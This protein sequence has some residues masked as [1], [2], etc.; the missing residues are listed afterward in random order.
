MALLGLF[1]VVFLPAAQAQPD[2]EDGP[3]LHSITLSSRNVTAGSNLVVSLDV[4][5]ATGIAQVFVEIR[6]PGDKLRLHSGTD[7][8]HGQGRNQ[9][10]LQCPFQL[11]ATLPA[12]TYDVWSLQLNDV[13]W[14]TAH[15]ASPADFQEGPL[16]RLTFTVASDNNDLEG[17]I[18]HGFEVLT[19]TAPAGGNA[20]FRLT[21]SDSTG[22]RTLGVGAQHSDGSPWTSGP[23]AVSGTSGAY[24]C[25]IPV[26]KAF[27]TGT[28]HVLSIDLVDV[29][30]VATSH[31][32]T[33]S[34]PFP[35][36]GNPTFAVASPS[37]DTTAPS[38][39]RFQAPLGPVVRGQQYEVR[40]WVD[41]A[42]DLAMA[43]PVFQNDVGK[44]YWRRHLDVQPADCTQWVSR[45]IPVVCTDVVPEWFP[46]GRVDLQVLFLKDLATNER[47]YTGL[48]GMGG[49]RIP[50]DGLNRTHFWIAPRPLGGRGPPLS[51]EPE[52]T[53]AAAGT[54]LPV[55]GLID[56]AT[57]VVNLTFSF[58]SEA[59][60]VLGAIGCEPAARPGVDGGFH[61]GLILPPDTPLGHYE[62]D[63]VVLAHPD[64][65][66][67]EVE[68]PPSAPAFD[69][70]AN[71]EEDEG[72]PLPDDWAGYVSGTVTMAQ[73][74]S[75]IGLAPLRTAS[76][77][78]ADGDA[79]GDTPAGQG[80]EDSGQTAS[81]GK[82]L[83]PAPTRGA[84]ASTAAVAIL[85]LCLA[86]VRLRQR[87]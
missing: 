47:Q 87:R 63:Q 67:V 82:S 59:G 18:L 43:F 78:I 36:L 75:G 26:P 86:V 56:E 21:A 54:V 51:L 29:N 19:P 61:C 77:G 50:E 49:E 32:R 20:T 27:P 3:A 68:L 6:G 28:Y 70:V 53:Q 42:T 48:S 38:L 34:S 31:Y 8:E 30:G 14:N 13:L 5:D 69:V 74:N 10:T 11:A 84:P 71:P 9:A 76:D 17:P 33:P 79:A 58:A 83:A 12:G 16:H 35:G 24:D 7:C 66:A 2:D 62:L 45:D 44:Q 52:V 37:D 81:P 22:L 57:S 15:V 41:D 55:A 4:T 60:R 25:S 23:C 85:A 40:I 80:D 65:S 39:V 64:G 46:L 72:A 1:L 73:F